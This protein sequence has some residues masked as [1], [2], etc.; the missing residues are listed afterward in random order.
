MNRS[1]LPVA[2]AVCLVAAV[3]CG[4]PQ[5]GGAAAQEAQW[6]WW[7]QHVKSEVPS[8]ACYFRKTFTM[9]SPEQ[10]QIDIGA[11][12]WY[13]LFV[14]G[15]R[16]GSGRSWRK[17][18]TYDVS[19][20]LIRGRNTIAVKVENRQGSTAGLTARVIVKDRGNTYVAHSTDGSWKT[21]LKPLPFWQRSAYSDRRWSKAQS[22]GPLGQT[23][24]WFDK[25]TV[26]DSGVK[27]RFHLP[28]KFGVQLVIDSK[29]TG[30]LIAMTFNEFGQ[31]IASREDGPLLLIYD[32]NKDNVL[33]RVRVYCDKV[34][35]CQGILALNGD[36]LVIGE[37]PQGAALYRL[38]DD[39][40]NGKLERV[41]AIVKFSG[42]VGEHGPH[43]LALG[44][45]GLIYVMLGNQTSVDQEFSA[46]SPHQHYYEGDLVGPRYEDPG[47]YAVGV[48]A[49][50]G[51]V[52]RTDLSGSRVELVA[53]G[54]RNAYDL[55]FNA[56]G[57]LFTHDSDMEWDE[58]TSWHRP[59]RVYHVTPGAEFGWRSGWAKWPDYYLD[60]L[61]GLVDTGRGSPAGIVAYDHF[62]FPVQY[63][64][65][66]FV[67]DWSQGRILAVHM[68]SSGGTYQAKSEVFLEG[69][70]LNATD[71]DVGPDGWLYFSTGGRGTEGGIY[72]VV[73]KG[74]VPSEITELGAGISTA[75]RQPQIHSAWSR[76]QIALV[77]KKLGDRWGSLLEAVAVNGRNQPAYRT[78][79]LDLMQLFGPPP[80]NKLLIQLSAEGSAE[81]RAK[82][83]EQM[84]LRTDKQTG[85]RLVALLEDAN[86]AVQRKACESLVRAGHAVAFDK[87]AP[88]LVS[89]DRYTSWAARRLVERIPGDRWHE[90]VLSTDSVR[91]FT[92]GA[93]AMMIAHPDKNA[94][95]SVLKR[96]G[97]L[98]TGFVG[99][100]DFVDLLRV[101]E[102]A[103]L[104][105]GVAGDDVPRL[106]QQLA[107]E[108]PSTHDGMNRELI[109]ILVHLQASSILD[110]YITHLES[111]VGDVEKLHLALHLRFLRSDWTTRQK[112]VL[113]KY[114]EDALS[115][116]GGEGLRRYVQAVSRDFAATLTDYERRL[117]LERGARW[118][119]AALGALYQISETLPADMLDLLKR[120][121]GQVAKRDDEAVK[122]LKVGIVAVLA[123]SG[124][125]ESMSY[126]RRI[127]DRDPERRMPVAIGLAQ[128]P[129]GKNW[130]Y[131]LKSLSFLEGPAAQ[132]VLVKLRSVDRVPDEPEHFRR[133]ILHGL[134]LKDNGGG[135]AVA[136]L[137]SWTGNSLAGDDDSWDKA[138]AAWQQW[139]AKTYPDEPEAKLPVDTGKNKWTMHDL[140][141]HLDSQQGSK[142]SAARGALVF[143]K[144][145]CNACHRY[146][147]EG[148]TMGSDLTSVSRRFQKKEILE[149]ILFPSYVIS[150]QYAAQTL[151][152][153]DGR[154]LTGLVATDGPNR[155]VL[156]QASG[157]KVTIRKDQIDQIRRSKTSLMPEGLLNSLTL[158]DVA[159]LMA[160]LSTPPQAN[161]TRRPRS[162]KRK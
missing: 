130:P 99:D 31:I 114:Y 90:A 9:R 128:D 76:Q 118:P 81:V 28:D 147:S 54:L 153:Q 124:D 5:L 12:D 10:G 161:I 14:N 84:G 50:G 83:V 126:L 145:Q 67:C 26:A 152:T 11:D 17:L 141:T 79:A 47:G 138:L 94:A 101:I 143:R 102:L 29:Q 156:L 8:G 62:M 133:V 146:G 125:A 60:N 88:L 85:Q 39:D 103:M 129:G 121:D 49:P 22:L 73:W 34:S 160:Y 56:V 3:L 6:I 159:D 63:Q 51:S 69:R 136:L 155:I 52:I 97:E 115:L 113:L 105:G 24:P 57:D 65:A 137:R 82:A 93:T 117:V 53:G 74:P 35:S 132:T 20:H 95:M 72:R 158:E 21:N 86:L 77:H 33:D 44:P 48:K 7:P 122:R 19:R 100:E 45:D 162:G 140:L 15:Q 38:S 151:T 120:L 37:G 123:R 109:R 89:E 68:Q 27:N 107:E 46:T 66:L 16:V 92:H 108:Y 112:L 104:R 25:N 116:P 64:D 154:S 42:Q 110:Q 43:G 91:L 58:G 32:S 134:K 36:V 78:R 149:S 59:T 87:V 150:D 111:D 96:A 71:I 135:L 98:M 127:Y 4:S 119:N 23:E 30:S 70:P 80:T 61:P 75:I 40:R 157:K 55:T 142:G 13:E 41:E 2:L 18:Q 1:Y 131:L 106:R 144:A 148:E 139:F